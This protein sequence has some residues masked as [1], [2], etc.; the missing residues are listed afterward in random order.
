MRVDLLP[1]QLTL[2]DGGAA[3]NDNARLP[4]PRRRTLILNRSA[5]DLL[6]GRDIDRE[7]PVSVHHIHYA[8]VDGGLSELTGVVAQAGAPDRNEP[9]DIRPVD[10]AKQTVLV[11]IVAHPE[12]CDVLGVLAVVDQLLRGLRHGAAAPGTEHQDHQ[13]FHGF[14]PCYVRPPRAK[15]NVRPLRHR[16]G[17]DDR[18]RE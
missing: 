18:F 5:P 4:D 2:V 9:L 17:D 13:F 8:V 12:R 1:E 3:A 6:T 16:A 10:L 7:R 15:V 11:E 14:P